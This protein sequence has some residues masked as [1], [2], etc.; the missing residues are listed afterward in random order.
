MKRGFSFYT[1]FILLFLSLSSVNAFS[2]QKSD[3]VEIIEIST[4]FGKILIWLH[5]ETPLHKQNF[6]K[7]AKE[8]LFSGTT[9]HRVIK[10]FVVQG[11]DPNTKDDNPENDGQGGPG[12]TVAAE[13]V[14]QLN[15]SYGAVAS[16]RMPDQVNPEKRSNGSQFY[17]VINKNG[18][19]HLNGAYTVFGRVIT[20]MDVAEMIADQTVDNR[21]R[22]VEDIKMEV[23]VV[24]MTLEDLQKNFNFVP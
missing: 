18:T 17:I 11:G 16:A 3:E 4:S 12:Y 15:H 13:F 10:N 2:Q 7:L 20:G 23:K 19:P 8:G 5:D 1:L 14:S 24:S 22:P 21:S 6:L 9:F